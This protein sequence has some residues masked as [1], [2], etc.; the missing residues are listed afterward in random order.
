[1]TV[2]V[3]ADDGIADRGQRGLRLLLFISQRGLE[4]GLLDD[5][6]PA[7]GQFQKHQQSGREQIDDGQDQLD[8]PR[9]LAEAFGE[10]HRLR[11]KPPVELIDVVQ[12]GVDRPVRCLAAGNLGMNGVGEAR[13]FIEKR[14]CGGPVAN[15]SLEGGNV[16]KITKQPDDAIDVVGMIAALQKAGAGRGEI[17]R[18][19]LQRAACRAIPKR[20]RDR[21]LILTVIVLVAA[22]GEQVEKVDGVLLSLRPQALAADISPHRGEDAEA[23]AGEQG[24]QQHDRDEGPRVSQQ[25]RFVMVELQSHRRPRPSRGR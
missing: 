21:L 6:V 1:M 19:L 8:L 7:V 22:V 20:D 15:R 5:E 13:Q 18:R 14:I 2:R 3:G 4:S 17:D 9:A 11:R 12:Q 24:L 16:A 23:G 25:T 10:F